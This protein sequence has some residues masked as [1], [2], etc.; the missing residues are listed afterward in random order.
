MEL[1]NCE[2]DCQHP[3]NIELCEGICTRN[4][5]SGDLSSECIQVICVSTCTSYSGFL[6]WEKT[7]ANFA[8]LCLFAK[9]FSAKIRHLTSSLAQIAPR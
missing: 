9:V 8:F 5:F 6:S 7:F 3:M 1:T 2:V 4:E